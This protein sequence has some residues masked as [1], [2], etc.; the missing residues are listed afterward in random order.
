MHQRGPPL[1]PGPGPR[2]SGTGRD[3]EDRAKGRAGPGGR[4]GGVV[5]TGPILTILP[6]PVPPPGRSPGVQVQ[7]K[8]ARRGGGRR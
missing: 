4:V 5:R 7:S 1:A 3:N 6:R 2:A 8:G